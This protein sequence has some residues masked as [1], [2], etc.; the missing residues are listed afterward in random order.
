[1]VSAVNRLAVAARRMVEVIGA[2]GIYSSP[3][4]KTTLINA[5]LRKKQISCLVQLVPEINLAQ[6]LVRKGA[7]EGSSKLG[8][9]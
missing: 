7:A 9:K 2:N 4:V 6:A 3:I 5:W 8:R 1:M